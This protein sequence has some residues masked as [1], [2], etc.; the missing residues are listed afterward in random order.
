MSKWFTVVPDIQ[1]DFAARLSQT[2]VKRDTYFERG[3]EIFQSIRTFIVRT[4]LKTE[5][6]RFFERH[7]ENYL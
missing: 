1:M 6:K 4:D 2:L 3:L 5:V 7:L